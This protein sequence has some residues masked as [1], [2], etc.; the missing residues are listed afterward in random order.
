MVW[1]DWLFENV[2]WLIFFGSIFVILL[3]LSSFSN[4]RAKCQVHITSWFIIFLL[5]L[6]ILPAPY[7]Y[8]FLVVETIFFI[9]L[10]NGKWNNHLTT[11]IT[12]NLFINPESQVWNDYQHPPESKIWQQSQTEVEL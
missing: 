4:S 2:D 9:W 11:E 3:T 7:N 8:S 12:N 10:L 1:N 5:L 6:L